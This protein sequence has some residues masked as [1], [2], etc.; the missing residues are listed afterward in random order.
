MVAEWGNGLEEQR[1][2]RAVNESL[3]LQGLGLFL[4][5]ALN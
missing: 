2:I 5:Y 1:K 3:H 4:V